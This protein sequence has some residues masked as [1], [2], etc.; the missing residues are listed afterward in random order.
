MSVKKKK[1][2]NPMARELLVSGKYS[3][4]IVKSKKTYSRREK[5]K[6]G[7]GK[8]YQ[9]PFSFLFFLLKPEINKRVIA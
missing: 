8:N 4:R 5:H 2:R 3:L 7:S 6:K 1:R 9:E